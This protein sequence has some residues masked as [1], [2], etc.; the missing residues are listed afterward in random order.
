MSFSSNII[1]PSAEDYESRKREVLAQ[2][3]REESLNHLFIREGKLS[4]IDE[5]TETII[6]GTLTPPQGMER[7][8]YYTSDRNH[9]F[10]Y[11][12]Q[13]FS[14]PE[15]GLKSHKKDKDYLICEFRK[16]HIG[17]ID[18]VSSCRRTVP[19]SPRDDDLVD[20]ILD[21]EAFRLIHEFELHHKKGKRFTFVCTSNNSLEAFEE[22]NEALGKPIEESEIKRNPY[23]N[24]HRDHKNYDFEGRVIRLSQRGKPKAAWIRYF[25]K[26]A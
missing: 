11:L 9:V 1:K 18:V 15:Y 25:A 21:V 10:G 7:G 20:I 3:G 5:D 23:E 16:R 24:D 22:I 19:D 17:F 13:A 4:L 26:C 8:F 14:D 2:P 6:V 12:D